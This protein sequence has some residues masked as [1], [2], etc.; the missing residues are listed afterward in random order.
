MPKAGQTTRR[1][2]SRAIEHWL[3]SVLRFAVTLDETDREAALS[4]AADMDGRGSGFTFFART[5]V[6]VCDAILAKDCAE[7]AEAVTA[8]R[9]FV[10]AIE[11]RRLRRAFEAVLYVNQSEADRGMASARNREW[12]WKG[13][14]IMRD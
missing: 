14:P 10:R 8:L 6:T 4:V 12:L 5:S 11:H 13:L 3:L 7:C 9:V 1:G 2:D